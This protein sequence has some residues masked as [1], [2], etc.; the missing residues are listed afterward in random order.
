M[1]SIRKSRN[2]FIV[3]SLAIP[4]ILLLMFV[5][6]PSVDLVA[7][8]FTSWDGISPHRDFVGV[9]NY[10]DMF[11]KSPDLWLSLR[12]NFIY[13]A[14]HMVMIPIELSIAVMLNTKFKGAGLVKTI[15][16]LPFI[17][18]GV[19][20]S[21]AFSYFF[22]PVNGAFNDILTSLGL[23]SWI[24]SWLSDPKVVNFVLASVS[25][26]RFSGYHIVLFSTGLTSI[27]TEVMEAARIDG[28]NAR[29]QLWRIQLPSIWL[30][31]SFVMFDC[32]RGTLQCFDIPF[33]MTNGGPGYAS[34]TFTL[35]TIDTAFKYNSFG[36][37]ATMAVAIMVIVIL[38]Y[39]FQNVVL[40][41]VFR[42]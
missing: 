33:I 20:M 30:V 37:A 34:S 1:K 14:V 9:G 24:Q 17:I 38:V 35:Y 16:F 41:K 7:M 15:A 6:Y 5:V 18:N 26:W 27:P 11:T 32:I 36:M 19:G 8:S 13:L 12:N 3:L 40:K 4:V 39:L 23:S 25:A 42:Q 10:V 22:S 29:Q 21:Y 28:A 2:R 31:F